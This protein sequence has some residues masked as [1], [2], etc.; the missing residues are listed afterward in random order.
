MVGDVGRVV[1]GV[2]DD[3][4]ELAVDDVEP[5]RVEDACIALVHRNDH[6]LRVVLE[7]VDDAYL[8]FFERGEV[9]GVSAIAT[10]GVEAEIFVAAGV[11]DVDEAAVAGPGVAA[12]IA[13]GGGGEASG[14]GEGGADLGDVDV[15]PVFPGFEESQMGAVGR[16]LVAGSVRVAEEVAEGDERRQGGGG[17]GC[18]GS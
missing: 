14:V 8:D 17:S 2:F 9:F 1:A 5:V 6:V 13:V 4:V 15:H 11:L 12:D 3:D 10:D 18:H 7:V 16:Q